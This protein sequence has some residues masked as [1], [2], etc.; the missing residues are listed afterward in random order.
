LL[1]FRSCDSCR[2]ISVLCNE[3][4]IIAK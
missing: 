1:D 3:T 2:L 4:H